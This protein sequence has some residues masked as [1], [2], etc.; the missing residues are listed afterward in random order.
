MEKQRLGEFKQL[1]KISVSG[2]NL[3]CETLG[4]NCPSAQGVLRPPISLPSFILLLDMA[5][6]ERKA[7]RIWGHKKGK[8]AP[9]SGIWLEARTAAQW[10]RPSF[11]S[12]ANLSFSRNLTGNP[13]DR[14]D[15]WQPPC[16]SS[17]SC[18]TCQVKTPS[19]A[20]R[21]KLCNSTCQ[22]HWENVS[23]DSLE[24][25]EP[26]KWCISF[27]AKTIHCEFPFVGT[28]PAPGCGIRSTHPLIYIT[29]SRLWWF[30][31][32]WPHKLIY[33]TAWS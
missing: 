29:S 6:Q 2:K 16:K 26:P 4:L 27:T 22:K 3:N 25:R 18:I 13:I 12:T 17:N 7:G 33:L 31:R 10:T 21:E 14:K 15:I 24:T 28:I 9:H 5:G 30:G 23:K 8:G 32:E 11:F 1:C 19:K 20:S